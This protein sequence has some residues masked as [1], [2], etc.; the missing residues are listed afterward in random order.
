MG[1]FRALQG[2]G[3]LQPHRSGLGPTG[4]GCRRCIVLHPIPCPWLAEK[5]GSPREVTLHGQGMLGLSRRCQG[6]GGLAAALVWCPPSATDFTLKGPRTGEKG[7]GG[8]MCFSPL[9]TLCLCS[10]IPSSQLGAWDRVALEH[11]EDIRA[12]PVP[13]SPGVHG[14][15]WESPLVVDVPSRSPAVP[16]NPAMPV[17]PTVLSITWTGPMGGCS[18]LMGP[19]GSWGPVPESPSARDCSPHCNARHEPA[20]S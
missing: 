3:H 2:E 4:V 11:L 10:Q 5:R 16:R 13:S 1:P 7:G 17:S 20:R 18:I 9:P 19:S 14:L 12:S 8:G 15:D 6:Q